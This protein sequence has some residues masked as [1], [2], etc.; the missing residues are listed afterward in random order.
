MIDKAFEVTA[1]GFKFFTSNKDALRAAAA[2][3]QTSASESV[4]ASRKKENN[5]YDEDNDENDWDIVLDEKGN[6]IHLRKESR[7]GRCSRRN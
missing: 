6:S 2:A 1:V 5:M 3:E 7:R 4:T